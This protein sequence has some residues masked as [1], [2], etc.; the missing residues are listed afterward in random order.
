MSSIAEGSEEESDEE[1]VAG[2]SEELELEDVLELSV[3]SSLPESMMSSSALPEF[4]LTS[5]D[6]N[7]PPS[8]VSYP[9]SSG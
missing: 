5:S 8:P 2:S 7:A 6:P 4:A 1:S 9:S 3:A